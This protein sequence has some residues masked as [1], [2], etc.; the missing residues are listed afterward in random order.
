MTLLWLTDVHFDFLK[1]K[2]VE[3]FGA[4][5][6]DVYPYVQGCIITGDIAT[7]EKT[8]PLLRRF[9]EGWSKPVHFVLGNHDYYN[10]SIEE[11]ERD[12]QALCDERANDWLSGR[13]FAWLDGKPTTAH[14]YVVGAGGW[15]DG[16]YGD[17]RKSRVLMTDFKRI[18]NLAPH[19]QESTW[20]W[21]PEA[22]DGMLD[23]LRKLAQESADAGERRLRASLQLNKNVIFAT[24]Y[25]PYAMACWHRGEISDREWLPWFTSHA[26]GEML[27]RVAEEHPEHKILVLCGHTHSEGVY[28]SLP[29]LRVLTGKAEYGEPC[30]AG[31]I[32][33][34]SFEW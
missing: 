11:V 13:Y 1:P 32:G 20:L 10:G 22:R 15:Y 28:E 33:E 18:K 3:A 26:M 4:E 30:V 8:V 5:L 7:A 14:S 2:V 29:N 24:H 25:P 27:D 16:R 23:L 6:R 31:V 19:F 9:M 34:K 21:Y 12:V 17:A